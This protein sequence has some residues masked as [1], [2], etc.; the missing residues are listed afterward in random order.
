MVFLKFFLRVIPWIQ[1]LSTSRTTQDNSLKMC[2]IFAC[3]QYVIQNIFFPRHT[4]SWRGNFHPSF[5]EAGDRF[6]DGWPLTCQTDT[7]MLRNSSLPRCGW[8]SSKW[9]YINS[10]KGNGMLTFHRIR[11]RGPD[12]SESPIVNSNRSPINMISKV[13]TTLAKTQVSLQDVG[14]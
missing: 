13:E 12:W 14:L 9:I 11:H 1:L 7:R 8:Q 6:C 3:H 5:C 10:F 2:G 4:N